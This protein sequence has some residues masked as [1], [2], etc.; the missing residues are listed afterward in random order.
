MV[1]VMCRESVC[2]VAR[3]PIQG[4]EEGG[5]GSVGG[6]CST[7]RQLAAMGLSQPFT[8]GMD[9]SS[10]AHNQYMPVRE[11]K[12]GRQEAPRQ[13]RQRLHQLQ[14]TDSSSVSK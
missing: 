9:G 3:V 11:G 12:R 8:Q 1:G 14:L 5:E 7:R 4:D 2:M 6:G 13:E 10:M